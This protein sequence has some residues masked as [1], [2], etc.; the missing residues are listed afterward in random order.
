M[1]N[2]SLTLFAAPL[3]AALLWA[4]LPGTN[5]SGSDQGD[6]L[7]GQ[8]LVASPEMDDPRFVE[9]VILMVRHDESGA[10]GIVINRPVE[11]R[12]LQSLM[13][14]LGEKDAD[15]SGTVRIFAGGPVEP[16]VGFVIH[17]AEYRRS[18]TMA[19][20]GH[21]SVTSSPE[22]LRDMGHGAGPAKSLVAFGY[23]G[24]GP[25]QIET[26]IAHHDWFSEPEDPQLVF[27]MERS[28]LWRQALDR[29]SRDL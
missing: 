17:S 25:G 27:D 29:R 6:K 15:A 20:D 10:F 14:D 3:A 24:W 13:D 7:V 1:A 2:R 12:S 16:A 11:E 23:A 4:A 28:I 22:I 19:I 5:D 8:L 26:E 18:V 9:T 21:L